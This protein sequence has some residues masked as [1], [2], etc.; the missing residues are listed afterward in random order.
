MDT[1][2]QVFLLTQCDT[3]GKKSGTLRQ[4]A[5]TTSKDSPMR[6]AFRRRYITAGVAIAGAS[7]IAVDQM[8]P[9]ASAQ[10]RAVQLANAGSADSLGDGTALIMGGTGVP[11]PSERYLDAVDTIYLQPRGFTGTLEALFTPEEFYPLTGVK[12]LTLDAS[13]AEGQQ[14][15]VDAILNQIAGGDVDAANP[16]VVFGYS[17][18]S[19]IASLTMAQLHDQGVASDDVHFVL[20]GNASNPNGGLLERFDLPAGTNPSIPSLGI[21]FGGT[22]PDNL[23]PTDVY[24]LEYDSAGDF[25]QYPLNVLSVL[26]AGMGAFYEHL[27]YLGLTPEQIQNAIPLE[28]TG[29]TLTHYYMIP[30]ENLPL[31]EPLRFS[32]VG[33]ALADLL[34]PDL[35]VL[36][37]VGYGSITDGWSQGPANVPTPIGLFP[38][39]INWADV[40]TALSNGLQ[41]GIN[42][43]IH[44][45]QNPDNYSILDN[46]PWSAL[47]AAAHVA[48]ITE[49]AHPSPSELLNGLVSYLADADASSSSPGWDATWGTIGDVVN[50]LVSDIPTYL[51]TL[52]LDQLEA[53]NFLGAIGLPLAVEGVLHDLF[54]I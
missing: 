43:A 40:S 29:D 12:S 15:L 20:V 45:L 39:D 35:R 54:G 36:V 32:V 26:N 16:V 53:G 27:T 1:L 19:T 51:N 30:V 52:S 47:L 22:T 10:V 14:N 34:Q 23:Y 2:R 18:S 46:P 37:N 6:P 44:D 48:G 4:P 11:L 7:L 49:T 24:T 5:P 9:P 17:Q 31:L 3:H 21:T 50:T 38:T 25:P 28:T 42:A 41:Q 13:I 8:A 33:N